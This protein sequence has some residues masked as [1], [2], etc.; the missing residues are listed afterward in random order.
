MARH[1]IQSVI[2]NVKCYIAIIIP[3]EG[4]MRLI[5]KAQEAIPVLEQSFLCVDFK[6]SLC[7][8]TPSS[9]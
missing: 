8:L 6:I 3:N 4:F 7:N 2:E 5:P 9:C 1:K